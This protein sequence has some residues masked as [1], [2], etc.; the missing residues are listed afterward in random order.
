MT[1]HRHALTCAVACRIACSTHCPCFSPPCSL[2]LLP[3]LARLLALLAHLTARSPHCSL[4]SLLARLQ[5]VDV[6]AP[7]EGTPLSK[8]EMRGCD[9]ITASKGKL[10]HVTGMDADALQASA[11]SQA[12]TASY[13]SA[14]PAPMPYTGA[15]AASAP[16]D[17]P[18]AYQAYVDTPPEPSAPLPAYDDIGTHEKV[19]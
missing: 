16:T 7:I 12:S 17:A 13:A 6:A 18:P 5:L 8:S 10:Y 9:P 19:A 2:A 3:C 15:A 1:R 14:G 11:S 4:I